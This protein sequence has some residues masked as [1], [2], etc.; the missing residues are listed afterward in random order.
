MECSMVLNVGK[1]TTVVFLCTQSTRLGGSDGVV[2]FSEDLTE[3][4]GH[5]TEYWGAL[6]ELS[7]D[8]TEFWGEFMVRARRPYGILRRAYGIPLGA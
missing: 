3:F 1:S 6:T 2:D 4:S 5:L 7:R 8:L